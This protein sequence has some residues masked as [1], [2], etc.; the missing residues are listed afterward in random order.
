MN[1]YYFSMSPNPA[2]EEVS[3]TVTTGNTDAASMDIE[4]PEFNVQIS[5]LSGNLYYAE[6]KS[7]L[8]FTL[9]VSNLKNGSYLVIFS[10]DNQKQ[11]IPLIVQH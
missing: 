2:S 10:Y 11:S 4:V 9:P 1:C 5:D 7:G 6:K 3:V 8:Y